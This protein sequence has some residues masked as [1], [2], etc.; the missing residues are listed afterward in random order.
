MRFPNFIPL[1]ILALFIAI[2]SRAEAEMTLS[3]DG[4][5]ALTGE[6]V[7]TST[8]GQIP[9][10]IMMSGQEIFHVGDNIMTVTAGAL[11]TVTEAEI[12]FSAV[13]GLDVGEVAVELGPETVFCTADGTISKDWLAVGQNAVAM[14]PQAGGP[15]IS[16][17]NALWMFEKQLM[18]IPPPLDPSCSNADYPVL[19]K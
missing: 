1:A 6:V 3:Y 11:M 13:D 9:N 19:V 4:K 16:V 14:V 18:S 17:R 7:M 10:N 5:A 8:A 2:G 12:R 15:A